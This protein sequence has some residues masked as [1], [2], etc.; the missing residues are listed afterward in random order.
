MTPGARMP[1]AFVDVLKDRAIRRFHAM[2]F[3]RC[4][5]G[6]SIAL[7]LG[8]AQRTQRERDELKRR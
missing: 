2:V 8:A 1:G 5:L 6:N 3:P 4:V 7:V